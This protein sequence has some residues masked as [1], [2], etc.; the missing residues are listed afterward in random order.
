MTNN[1]AD[2]AASDQ[3]PAFQLSADDQAMLDAFIEA[4]YKRDNVETEDAN[5]AKR[6][7]AVASVFSLLE[8]YPVEDAHESLISATI[9]RIHRVEEGSA[10][11]GQIGL[12]EPEEG[13][14]RWRIPDF[15]SIAA[16][17]LIGVS[18]AWPILGAVR[19]RAIDTA[20]V[21]NLSALGTGFDMFARD[22][23]G[24]VPMA[25]AGF[26]GSVA[27]K[28]V[29]PYALVEA[30]YCDH[31]HCNCPGHHAT[32]GYSRQIIPSGEH[33]SWLTG[34]TTAI[35]GDRNPVIDARATADIIDPHANSINHRGRGQNILM[36]DIS[37]RWLEAPV[38][39]NTTD[40]IWLIDGHDGF[41][42]GDMPESAEADIFLAH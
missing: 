31:N 2:S 39:D 20:C 28:W 36:K 3:N 10:I 42:P 26:G 8:D 37:T 30:S 4:G 32:S 5:D 29:D 7:D 12:N 33:F 27:A 14:S 19:Q 16:I 35:I 1:S 15:V 25:V 22:N 21:T 13:R 24:Q 41:Q 40:N 23:H 6:L 34:P 9:A 11:A 38:M 17:I 18:V